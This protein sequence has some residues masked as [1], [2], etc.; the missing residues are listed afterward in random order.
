MV[1][2]ELIFPLMEDMGAFISSALEVFTT[3]FQ[4]YSMKN[5][6]EIAKMKKQIEDV[7][8]N[9]EK[10]NSRVIGFTI[11]SASEEE[12]EEEEY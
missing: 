5:G 2:G 3:T 11:P 6:V 8:D 10:E 7:V 1:F 4:K 12:E 9:S